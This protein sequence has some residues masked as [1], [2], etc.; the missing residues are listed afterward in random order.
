MSG[1]LVLTIIIVLIGT[2]LVIAFS[3]KKDIYSEEFE[4]NIFG[5]LRLKVKNKEKRFKDAATSLN[6]MNKN[7]K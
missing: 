4:I 7:H 5:L 3:D 2:I 6:R 1:L